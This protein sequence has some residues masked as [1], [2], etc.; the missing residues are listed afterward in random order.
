MEHMITCK[1]VFYEKAMSCFKTG[2]PGAYLS[3][4]A[5][6]LL[7]LQPWLFVTLPLLL[8]SQKI[9]LY[10]SWGVEKCGERLQPLCDRSVAAGSW[11]SGDTLD[12]SVSRTPANFTTESLSS[13][14]GAHGSK[15]NVRPWSITSDACW[16]HLQFSVN[17][18]WHE[19]GEQR[20]RWQERERNYV[21][22][23]IVFSHYFGSVCVY[24]H[25]AGVV[26]SS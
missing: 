18:S 24:R 12:L 1:C 17:F 3:A 16:H 22:V 25:S 2:P 15:T 7:F 6:N 13:C 10:P 21:W 20:D 4:L 8:C 23:Q 5:M 9:H 14:G 26:R 11:S 19:A